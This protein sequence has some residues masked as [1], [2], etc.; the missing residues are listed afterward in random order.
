MK[1]TS[2]V[3]A[4]AVFAFV[5]VCVAAACA[6][7]YILYNSASVFNSSEWKSAKGNYGSCNPRQHMVADVRVR[8]LSNR[9]SHADVL[10]MLGPPDSEAGNELRYELGLTGLFPIDGSELIVI[11][12][13]CGIVTSTKVITH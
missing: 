1:R 5:L 4:G 10:S 8:L 3:R 7:Y 11:F 2:T 9:L 13:E 6:S 12:D